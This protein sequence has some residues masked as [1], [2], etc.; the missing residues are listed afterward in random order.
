MTQQRTINLSHPALAEATTLLLKELVHLAEASQEITAELS[1]DRLLQLIVDRARSLVGCQYAALSVIDEHRRITSFVT[2][3]I[4]KKARGNIGDLPVGKGILGLILD[5]NEPLRLDDA[6]QHPAAAGFPPGHPVMK[7]FLGIAIRYAG[8]TFGNLYLTEKDGGQPFS[9]VDAQ[10]VRMFAA[11]V[12][13][14]LENARL[15]AETTR[16]RTEAIQEHLS[17]EAILNSMAEGIYTLD[18]DWRITRVNPYA[19]RVLGKQPQEVMGLRCWEVFQYQT[20]NGRSLCQTSC[21]ARQAIAAERSGYVMEA[22]LPVQDR[23]VPVALLADTIRDS[24][25]RV[26]GVVETVRD[27]SVRKEADEIRDSIV[28]LVSHELRTPLSHIKGFSSSLLQPDVQWDEETKADFIRSI[29]READRLSRLVSDLLDMS[30]L[31]SG[32]T[33]MRPE[34]VDAAGLVQSAIERTASFLRDHIVEV[35]MPSKLPRMAADPSQTER[36][37]ENLLEN[38]AK[39]SFAGSQI[40][41]T[42][43][44]DGAYMLL[45]VHDQG[46]GIPDEDKERVFERFVRLEQNRAFR[47]PGTGLGLSICKSIVE[48]HG[49]RIWVEDNE[50]G[51]GNGSSFYLTLP[52]AMGRRR[53]TPTGK[54]VSP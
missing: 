54:R 3:G 20:L 15:F 10:L 47:S 9:E 19:A 18:A 24:Q 44:A 21:P 7:T 8:K 22:I 52:L 34:P 46:I 4:D 2:S 6:S 14:A 23:N 50:D 33:F 5:T 48:A 37:L 42:A 26:V 28:S 13:I 25:G 43:R 1:A 27:I 49:G 31:D 45:G 16:Q 38:A 36:V 30:R 51:G 40:T 35:E 53:R 39:Y 41:V 11:Q 17:L 32:R 12:G 29:D